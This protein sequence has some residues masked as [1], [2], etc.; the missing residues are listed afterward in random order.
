M[1][2][3]PAT[4]CLLTT[5][6]RCIHVDVKLPPPRL[7]LLYVHVHT[8]PTA[9]YDVIGGTATHFIQMKRI[10]LTVSFFSLPFV[11]FLVF[12]QYCFIISINL[13]K[14]ILQVPRKNIFLC[15]QQFGLNIVKYVVHVHIIKSYRLQYHPI[16]ISKNSTIHIY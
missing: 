6:K 14:N 11:N 5:K 9:H 2:M 3:F 13:N 1:N 8:V 15:L 16:C 7:V 12:F 10:K 4:C